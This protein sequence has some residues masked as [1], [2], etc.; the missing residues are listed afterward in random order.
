[1]SLMLDVI[2]LNIRMADSL[3]KTHLGRAEAGVSLCRDGGT[4]SQR[5]RNSRSHERRGLLVSP[6]SIRTSTARSVRSSSRSISNSAKVR[7]S[8]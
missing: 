3:Q 1:M 7:L 6:R 8:G 5:R 4:R 2:G